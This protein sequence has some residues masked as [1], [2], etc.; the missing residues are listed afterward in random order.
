M[1]ADRILTETFAE[2]EHLAPDVEI[3][4]AGIARRLEDRRPAGGRLAVAGAAATVVAVAVGAS[5]LLGDRPADPSRSPAAS[6]TLTAPLPVD[7]LKVAPGW[8]P[9]GEVTPESVS[10]GYGVQTRL[11]QIARPSG[12]ALSV[13]VGTSPGTELPTR[14][15][16]RTTA[17]DLTVA[18]RAARE[19]SLPTEYYVVV[20]LPQARLATVSLRS[21]GG[22]AAAE[23]AGIGRQVAGRLQLDR[24][25]PIDVSYELTSLPSGRAV[26]SVDVTLVDDEGVIAGG[27]RYTVAAPTTT[28]EQRKRQ[29]IYVA[30]YNRSFH[31]MEFRPQPPALPVRP[32]QGRPVQGRPTWIY[33]TD[34]SPVLWVDEIRPGVSIKLSGAAPG[35]TFAELYRIADG[36]RWTG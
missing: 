36:I 5:L 32:V 25:E 27:T 23:L 21:E 26:M 3:T 9:P 19:W 18:G 35:T 4:L 8:L 24:P 2:H 20:A 14:S 30:Q 33:S 10:T 12:M 7:T 29:S 22:D 11:Y 17:R 6:P 15:H 28:E 34:G 16:I 31:T 1:T 13:L